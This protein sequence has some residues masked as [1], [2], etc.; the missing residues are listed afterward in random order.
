MD[1][2]DLL[3]QDQGPPA[4]ADELRAIVARAGRKRWRWAAGGVVAALLAGGAIGYGVS[5]HPGHSGSGQTLVA[6]PDSSTS[7]TGSGNPSAAVAPGAGPSAESGSGSSGSA[8]S[9]AGSSS[10]IVGEPRAFTRLFTRTGG[11]VTI[12]GFLTSLAQPTPAQNVIGACLAGGPGFQA[13]VSTAGMVGTLSAWSEPAGTTGGRAIIATS[14]EVLGSAEGD[15]VAVVAV[16]SSPEVARVRV[17]FAAGGSDEMAP[18]NGW[19]ALAA[20]VPANQRSSSVN[21][22]VIGTA[23]ALGS[24]GQVLAS[25]QVGTGLSPIPS[26]CLPCRLPGLAG[27]KEGSPPAQAGASSGVSSSPTSASTGNSTGASTGQRSAGSGSAFACPVE[28]VPSTPAQVK[29]VP[30]VVPG[31]SS[32][33]S[34]G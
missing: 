12:R 2:E 4:G 32:E 33:S 30:G 1:P 26:S 8:S 34:S 21:E 23:Q 11:T 19:A 13:E 17:E 9:G 25:A 28:V 31:A 29:P 14:G 18:V 3:G 6:G 15:P 10:A 16:A 22:T 27:G 20:V 24:S 5:N 7:T